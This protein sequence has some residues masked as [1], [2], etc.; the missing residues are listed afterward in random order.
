MWGTQQLLSVDAD[1][2]SYADRAIRGQGGVTSTQSCSQS[3]KTEWLT[4]SKAT[5]S[6]K[7]QQWAAPCICRLIKLDF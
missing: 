4:V 2:N 1:V 3:N 6:N 5:R 7:T